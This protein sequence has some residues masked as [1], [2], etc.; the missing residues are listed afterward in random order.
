MGVVEQPTR[1]AEGR[2][3]AFRPF[4]GLI[5]K[6]AKGRFGPFAKP[7]VY[8]RY[9]RVPADWNR[10]VKRSLTVAGVDDT[11]APKP[12]PER[13]RGSAEAAP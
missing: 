8:D 1:S 13:R 3:L 9:L 12:L 5:L 2:F 4:I 11:V 7:P 10:R 6:A